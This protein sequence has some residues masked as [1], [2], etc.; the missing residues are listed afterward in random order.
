MITV[1]FLADWAL[2]STGLIASGALL[3]K[4]LRVKDPSVRLAAWTAILCCSSA[5]PLLTVSLPAIPVRSPQAAPPRAAVQPTAG[6]VVFR[7]TDPVV[8]RPRRFDW[9]RGAIDVYL[10]VAALLLCRMMLGI[11]MT[12]RLLRGSRPVELEGVRESGRIASPVTLGVLWPSILLP[13]DWRQWDASKLAAVLAHERAHIRRRDPLVQSLSALHRA[14]LWF[15]PLSWYLDRQIVRLAEEASDDAAVVAIRDRVV[16]AETLLE[17][18][19]RSA[20]AARQPGVP[21]ARYG[22]PE[23][24]IHRILDATTFSRGVTRWTLAAILALG[25]P[26]AYVVAAAQE[27]LTF[28]AASVKSTEVPPGVTI[29]GTSMT[30][31]RREDFQR[32]RSTGGPG[33]T[34]PGRIHYPLVSLTGLLHR[35]Y[36]DDYFEIEIPGWADSDVVSVDATMP[37]DTT[38][39]HFHTM[40][41]NLIVDR[42]GLKTHTVSKEIGGYTLTVAKGGPKLSGSASLEA[43]GWP[44]PR[45]ELHGIGFQSMPGERA[46][47]LG[48]GISLDVL[49]KSLGGLLDSKVIDATGIT[50]TFEFSLTFAGHLGGP[51]GVTALLQP[52]EAS[53]DASAP[54][55]LPDIFSA[56]QT[57]LGLKL[58]AKKVP[59]EVLV[60]DHLEKTPVGN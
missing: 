54:A 3:L 44:K 22:A 43:E 32:Y 29:S 24:R 60:V 20:G 11:A 18:V 17:F 45:G 59:V 40:L 8:P 50:G 35:A 56:L 19:Q 34:D 26:V 6:T 57:Q 28:E 46:R 10:I 16:Y 55:P 52:P 21:M 7:Q 36:D 5:L 2:R 58:E 30:M 4:V 37:A 33:S 53:D 12:V 14:L 1:G 48:A 38:K 15:S 41:Q 25:L 42:F 13:P 39:E 51:H 31:S 47:M 27:R 23:R 49:A 9:R